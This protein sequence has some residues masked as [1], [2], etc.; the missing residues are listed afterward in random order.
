[1]KPAQLTQ[2]SEYVMPDIREER[3]DVGILFGTRHGVDQFC[4]ETFA[5]WQREMFGKLLITGGCTH[6]SKES[7]ACIIGSRLVKMG[8]PEER[9]V[10]EHEA[11][12][13]GEN[14]IYGMRKLSE[15]M[16]ITS[17]HSVLAIGKICSAR[18][19]LMTL[20]QHWPAPK[21][22]LCAINYFGLPKSRWHDHDEFRTRVL[23]EFEKIPEYVR[24]GFLR[25]IESLP[26]YPILSIDS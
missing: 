11:T 20:E 23:S 16:D 2:I 21:K 7:E 17:I 6:D 26:P 24:R 3:S 4:L 5:L 12:N 19:Y 1:M 15:V 14:V 18:R 9:L 22:S 8:M 25:E 13:T 10:L